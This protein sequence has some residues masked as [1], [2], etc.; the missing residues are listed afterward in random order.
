MYVLDTADAGG[1]SVLASG[2]KIYNEIAA[3]RPDVIR[4]LDEP[5]WNFDK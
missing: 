1:E 5:F 4:L 2:G 3:S